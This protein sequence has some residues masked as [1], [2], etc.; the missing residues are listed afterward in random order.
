MIP[1]DQ[2]QSQSANKRQ[3][4]NREE[5]RQG[6]AMDET[7]ELIEQLEDTVFR[8]LLR[9]HNHN[10]F[11]WLGSNVVRMMKDAPSSTP[12]HQTR[13]RQVSVIWLDRKDSVGA[14]DS[15]TRGRFSANPPVFSIPDAMIVLAI[16]TRC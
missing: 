15:Y 14:S 4:D 7:A 16:Q 8:M 3:E 5:Q 10:R 11:D 12:I 9:D 13:R 1:E 2:Q 6:V